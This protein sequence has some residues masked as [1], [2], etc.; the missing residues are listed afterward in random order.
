MA[1]YFYSDI[2][3]CPNGYD[4]PDV[5]CDG[6]EIPAGTWPSQDE[7]EVFVEGLYQQ[8]LPTCVCYGRPP[9]ST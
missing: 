2:R 1:V 8:H 6:F 3:Y 5:E 7:Y 4:Y 9:R